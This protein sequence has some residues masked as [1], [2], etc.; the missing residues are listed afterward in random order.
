MTKAQSEAAFQEY[1]N[2]RQPALERLRQALAD[3]SQDPDALLDG[4]IESPVPLW[5]WIL[6]HA[7][8]ADAPGTTDATFYSRAVI[9]IGTAIGAGEALLI[10]SEVHLFCSPL[11]LWAW[12]S[13]ESPSALG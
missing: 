9:L 3:N 6:A 4:S 2:E 1:L 10:L 11:E 12:E 7:T 13:A 8:G 5:R